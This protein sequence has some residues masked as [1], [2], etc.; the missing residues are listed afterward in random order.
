MIT[1]SSDGVPISMY[2]ELVSDPA[3]GVHRIG[4]SSKEKGDGTMMV[5]FQ[6]DVDIDRRPC[7]FATAA[8]R[9]LDLHGA[10]K[11]R[12]S[13]GEAIAPLSASSY[14]GATRVR[15]RFCASSGN[16]SRRP[17]SAAV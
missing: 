11:S 10:L 15:A 12:R 14:T 4:G 2:S 16:P 7:S 17:M 5:R 9:V 3:G 8:D 13:S 1:E 6:S